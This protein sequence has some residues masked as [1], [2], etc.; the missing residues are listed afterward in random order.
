MPCA[1]TPGADKKPVIADTARKVRKLL[2]RFIFI[3]IIDV[4]NLKLM[5][6]DQRLYGKCLNRY[7]SR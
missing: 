1:K 5:L 6:A 4:V 3:F 7:N 2:K